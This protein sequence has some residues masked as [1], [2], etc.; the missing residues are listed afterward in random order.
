MKFIKTRL[1]ERGTYKYKFKTGGT[2][3]LKPGENGVTEVDIK[4]LHS[5]DDSEVY[6]NNK[7]SKPSKSKKEKQ[8]IEKWK[9][10]YIDKFIT[11]YGYE[12]DEKYIEFIVEERFPK[13]YHSRL[14]DL[15]QETDAIDKTQLAFATS[16]SF[17]LSTEFQIAE[18]KKNLLLIGLTDLQ[19]K[20]FL[21]QVIEGISQTEIAEMLNTSIPNVNKHLKKAINKIKENK[22]LFI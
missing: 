14:D 11:K 8:E 4:E 16:T 12:P 7:N 17:S 22:D 10:S 18:I 3:E 19:L 21:L 2:I 1:E 13:N 15:L 5:F 6:N 20:V 9:K